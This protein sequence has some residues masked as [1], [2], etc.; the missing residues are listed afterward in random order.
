MIINQVKNKEDY[1]K[2]YN[3]L[4]SPEI[5]GQKIYRGWWYPKNYNDFLK[6]QMAKNLG[7]KADLTYIDENKYNRTNDTFESKHKKNRY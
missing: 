7:I 6:T 4:K 2:F 3:W 5:K 1:E